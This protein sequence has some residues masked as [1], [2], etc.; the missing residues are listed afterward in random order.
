MMCHTGDIHKLT[1]AGII[2]DHDDFSE[3][4]KLQI[5]DFCS[6][7]DSLKDP[8]PTACNEKLDQEELRADFNEACLHKKECKINLKKYLKDNQEPSG[9][10]SKQNKRQE[11]FEEC[12]A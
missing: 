7:I 8:Q 12:L 2:P 1:F 5:N 3:K 10:K 6:P 11:E 4:V 9:S